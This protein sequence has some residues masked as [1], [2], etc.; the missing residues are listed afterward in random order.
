M[1]LAA[2]CGPLCFSIL[3]SV[4][5]VPHAL[6][7]SFLTP[8]P[9][10]IINSTLLFENASSVISPAGGSDLVS[11]LAADDE[12]SS[13]TYLLWSYVSSFF[14]TFQQQPNYQQQH[15]FAAPWFPFVFASLLSLYACWLSLRISDPPPPATAT[16][17]DPFDVIRR[18]PPVIPEAIVST[19]C[20]AEQ[21][22]VV[23]SVSHHHHSSHDRSSSSHHQ[24]P[25]LIHVQ[26]P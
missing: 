7:S 17:Y 12:S 16:T 14:W 10:S 22:V 20:D 11:S 19:V 9:S 1:A 25:F 3:F 18:S 21:C 6:S 23:S 24:Q 26:T 8:L 13:S 2:G 5:T 15:V 4:F